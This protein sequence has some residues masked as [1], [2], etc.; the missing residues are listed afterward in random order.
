MTDLSRRSR[1]LSIVRPEPES[2]IGETA[3]DLTDDAPSGAAGVIHDLSA[4]QTA[5]AIEIDGAGVRYGRRWVLRDCSL[6]IPQGRV[7]AVVGRNG[8]GKTSLLQ[9][10]V[11]LS[12]PSA[13]TVRVL[14]E[15]A[16][17]ASTGLLSQIGFVAQDKPLYSGVRVADLIRMGSRLNP[18]WD[19]PYAAERLA[20]RGVPLDAKIGKLSG[21][22]RAQVALVMALAKR[23]SLLVLDEPLAALDPLA[24]REVLS[25]LMVDLADRPVTVVLSSHGLADLTRVCDWLVLVDAGRVLVSE[26][27]DVLL[28]GHRLIVGPVEQADRMRQRLAVVSDSRAERQARLMVRGDA[29]ELAAD[30]RWDVTEPTLEELVFAHLAASGPTS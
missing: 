15:P 19:G 4:G 17:P 3:D 9:M 6:R 28:A 14:D 29:R 7:V 1:H 20:D 30:P 23:P 11:G 24:R 16:W 26:P 13:G 2:S 5:P 10:M 12:R 22:Q 8:A 25:A 18:S 27:I 21:G